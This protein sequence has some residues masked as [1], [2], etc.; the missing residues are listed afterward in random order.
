VRALQERERRRETWAP[1]WFRTPEGDPPVYPGEYSRE[2]CPMWEWTGAYL[3]H[4]RGPL[5]AAGAPPAPALGAT[6]VLPL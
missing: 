2:E 1:R 6:A 4:Q 3:Q 5:P